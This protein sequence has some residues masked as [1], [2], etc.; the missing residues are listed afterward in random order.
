MQGLTLCYTQYIN[1]KYKRTGRLWESRYHS[2]IVDKE[3][4]MWA[5]ARYIEQNPTRARIVKKEE[6]FPYSSARAHVKGIIDEVLG[7][8]LFE[9]GQRK[10]YREFIRAAIPQE[11]KNRI[12]YSTRTG[13]PFGSETFVKKMEKKLDRRFI[14]GSPGRPKKK[15]K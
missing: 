7:E 2:C 13:R 6:D 12:R 9:E 11:E 5:V 1:K 8:E 15:D 4:Y 10:D 14:L 3:Q